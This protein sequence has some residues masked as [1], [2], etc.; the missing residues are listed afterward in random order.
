MDEKVLL[1]IAT[2]CSLIGILLLMVTAEK[3]SLEDSKIGA[4]NNETRGQEVIVKGKITAIR[5]TPAIIILTLKDNTGAIKVVIFKDEKDIT[6]KRN[7]I[8]EVTGL[9]KE[10]R[11]ENEIEADLVKIF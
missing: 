8:V 7:D 4:I 1:K 10:Y 2:I 6:L 11:N 5:D 9:V 3:V